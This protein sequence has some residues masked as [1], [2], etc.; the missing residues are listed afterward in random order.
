MRDKPAAESGDEAKMSKDDLIKMIEN[1][2]F[3]SVE[4]D[5]VY[6]RMEKAAV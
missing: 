5:T 2:G 1:A 3:E 6:N 4:R